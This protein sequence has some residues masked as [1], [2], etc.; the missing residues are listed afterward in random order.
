MLRVLWSTLKRLVFNSGD[1]ACALPP[2]TLT[3]E[4]QNKLKKATVDMALELGVK[5][6]MNV[7]FA[8]QGD[9]IYVLEVNP[10]ASRT[11]PFVSKVTCVPLAKV[12]TQVMLG[13]TLEDLGLKDFKPNLRHVG[14]KEAALPFSRFPGTDCILGPE[15]KSTGE[16]MGIDKDFAIA[17]AK[18][19]FGVGM[20][21]PTSGTAF[22]SVMDSDKEMLLPLA[23][24]LLKLGFK[25]I[26]TRGTHRALSEKNIEATEIKKLSVGSP[27]VVD[28]IINEEVDILINTPSGKNPHKDEIKIRSIATERGLPLIT[29]MRAAQMLC[30]AIEAHKNG[31]TMNVKSMQE[32]HAEMEK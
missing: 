16:V 8:I 26:A 22:I 5:G 14:V 6:L 2:F 27:N 29:T 11:V 28:M 19:E 20:K 10:R 25:L 4:T 18:A 1:S 30:K 3:E 12:A 31:L 23:E 15:M 9:E 17:F 21:L 7:Q 32:Y 24:N 13:K